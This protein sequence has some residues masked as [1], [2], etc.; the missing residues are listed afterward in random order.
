MILWENKIPNGVIL[1]S[2]NTDWTAKVADECIVDTWALAKINFSK[3]IQFNSSS[4]NYSSSSSQ[5]K[6][7]ICSSDLISFGSL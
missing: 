7:Q 4:Q 6:N 1:P 3:Q 2:E 5:S